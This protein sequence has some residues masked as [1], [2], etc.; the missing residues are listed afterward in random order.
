MQ[1]S[2][3]QRGLMVGETPN[4]DRIGNEGGIFMH[5][6]AESSCTVG[7]TA[8]ITG[9]NPYRGGCSC[10]RFPALFRICDPVRRPS[11]SSC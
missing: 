11:P 2:I 4:I 7:R 10:R 1:P 9:M 3:Y 8:F 5:Y 6:Y